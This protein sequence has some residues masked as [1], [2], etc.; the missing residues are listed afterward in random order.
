MRGDWREF[1]KLRIWDIRLIFIFS[2]QLRDSWVSLLRG[3]LKAHISLMK[4]IKYSIFDLFSYSLPGGVFILSFLLLIPEV[5]GLGD[6]AS[7]ISEINIGLG[8]VLIFVAYILGNAIDTFGSLI[9]YGIGVKIWK[10]PKGKNKNNPP[11]RALIR[12]F[13]PENNIYI[14]Q[15]KV[16]KTM[17]H[18]LSFSFLILSLTSVIKLIINE[19]LNKPTFIYLIIGSIILSIVFLHRA[20]IFDKWHYNDLTTVTDALHL[21]KKAQTEAGK[22]KKE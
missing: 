2:L 16:A 1:G 22:A 21:E 14:Q 18:N 19:D 13:S 15:W 10:N 5:K 17:S 11:K 7:I 6:L 20:Y 9:Y 8:V 12:E 3:R 4:D